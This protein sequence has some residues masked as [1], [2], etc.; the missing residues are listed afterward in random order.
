MLSAASTASVAETA[1]NSRLYLE[2]DVLTQGFEVS[3]L[4]KFFSYH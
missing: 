2:R 4:R 3:R 1:W